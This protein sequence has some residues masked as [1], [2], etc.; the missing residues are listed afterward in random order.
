MSVSLA[1]RRANHAEWKGRVLSRSHCER[2][3]SDAAGSPKALTTSLRRVTVLCM[4]LGDHLGVESHERPSTRERRW[5]W[6]RWR[7]K[8]FERTTSSGRNE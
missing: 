4:F 3:T 6:R 8:R 2:I 1:L 5:E 7:K